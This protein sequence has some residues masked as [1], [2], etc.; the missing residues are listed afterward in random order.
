MRN[1]LRVLEK[2]TFADCEGCDSSDKTFC[3]ICI[4]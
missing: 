1:P 4:T 2:I 3:Y